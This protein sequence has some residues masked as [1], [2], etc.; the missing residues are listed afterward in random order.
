MHCHFRTKHKSCAH[1]MHVQLYVLVKKK[2]SMI[3]K[4]T[5]CI[6]VAIFRSAV[7]GSQSQY[8]CVGTL[9]SLHLYKTRC[10]WTACLEVR[11]VSGIR[12]PPPILNCCTSRVS[13]IKIYFAWL[14]PPPH[15]RSLY[16][17]V[18]TWHYLLVNYSRHFC[19]CSKCFPCFEITYHQET[20]A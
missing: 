13:L 9:S 7:L 8:L 16:Y 19:T 17:F 18:V 1:I 10:I 11:C 15:H 3:Q 20:S 4:R 12:A 5:L 2:M 14:Q 6:S